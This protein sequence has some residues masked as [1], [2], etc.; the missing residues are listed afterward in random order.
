MNVRQT[1]CRHCGQDIEGFAPYRKGEWRDRGNNT[2]CPSGPNKGRKHAPFVEP[3]ISMSL[4][5]GELRVHR[6]TR[7]A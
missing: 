7:K 2:T 3:R 4:T 1:T 6:G 5:T